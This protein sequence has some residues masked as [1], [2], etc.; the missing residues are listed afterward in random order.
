MQQKYL[1]HLAAALSILTLV[2]VVA[3][4]TRV[5]KAT[6]TALALPAAL[7]SYTLGA[8]A[9]QVISITTLNVS[10]FQRRCGTCG[11]SPRINPRTNDNEALDAKTCHAR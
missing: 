11:Q 9:L 3:H 4:D 10:R 6:I 2:G 5:D 8:A 7:A 1:N